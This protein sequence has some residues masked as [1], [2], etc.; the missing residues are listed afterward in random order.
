MPMMKNSTLFIVKK[1]NYQS[2]E[3]PEVGKTKADSDLIEME[4]A[5]AEPSARTI[6]NIMDFA[7][8]YNVCETK[9]TGHVEMILN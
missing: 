2:V 1:F 6:R 7:R 5:V 3:R 4:S 9:T 8:S